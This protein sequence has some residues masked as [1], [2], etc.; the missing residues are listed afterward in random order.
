MNAHEA[1][2][3][4]KQAKEKEEKELQERASEVRALINEVIKEEATKGAQHVTVKIPADIAGL[5]LDSLTFDN[6]TYVNSGTEKF[7]ISWQSH[8]TTFFRRITSETSI[9]F[10]F[11]LWYSI[12]RTNRREEKK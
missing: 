10:F 2:I 11:C 8:E 5:V 4:V 1:R 9:D 7:T 12:Y 6:F 3:L